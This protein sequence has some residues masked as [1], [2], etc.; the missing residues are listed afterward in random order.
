MTKHLSARPAQKRSGF[1]LIEL[2]VVI[3][4]IGILAAILLPALARAREAARRASC[5]NNLKQWGL[6]FKM[7]AGEDKAG[8]FPGGNE[9]VFP[10]PAFTGSGAWVN[11]MSLGLNGLQLY[12]EY[13]TDANIAVCPSDA[14]GDLLGG[15]MHIDDLGAAVANAAERQGSP[16]GSSTEFGTDAFYAKWCLGALLSAP[17]SYIY[18]P[19][20]TSTACQLGAVLSGSWDEA[21]LMDGNWGWSNTWGFPSSM[22]VSQVDLAPFGCDF[23]SAYIGGRLQNDLPNPLTDYPMRGTY[24]IWHDTELIDDDGVSPMPS[25]YYHLREGIERFFITDINNP[26]ESNKAQSEIWV[27]F[28]SWGVAASNL[29]W[30]H[31]D[32]AIIRFNHI[33]GGSN[34]LYMDGHT[35]FVRYDSRPPMKD[36]GLHGS[37]G[38]YLSLMMG[39]AG[40]MG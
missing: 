11:L 40:G 21:K 17:I 10:L 16:T 18:V 6:I 23:T 33:P 8:N 3:A 35:E 38:A 27:M 34:V 12:P 2:L 36:V 13:W 7:Y 25:H 28:D 31:D 32:N 22:E 39:S 26:A 37:F 24:K 19:V 29:S 1:T 9:F 14:H 20:A 4:I 30:D 15:T 5:A